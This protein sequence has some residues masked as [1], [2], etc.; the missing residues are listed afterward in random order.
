MLTVIIAFEF[1]DAELLVFVDHLRSGTM[2]DF[3]RVWV[4]LYVGR[5]ITF[6]SLDV[7]SSYLHVQYISAQYG[8]VRTC[9]VNS[10]I[11]IA[12]YI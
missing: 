10:W 11:Y 1:L 5:T 4:C 6:E 2:Y 3:G 12:L 8:S 9:K 7:G